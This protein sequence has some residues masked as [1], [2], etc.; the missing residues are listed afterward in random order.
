MGSDMQDY[1]EPLQRLVEQFRRLPGIGGKSAVRMAFA[2]L[3]FSE[4]EAREFSEAIIDAKERITS[5]RRCGNYS[6]GEI[7]PICADPERD[8]GLV[9]VLENARDILA[10]ER[11]REYRGLY[12]VLGGSLSPV[13]GITPDALN[14]KALV[15]RVAEGEIREIIVA[16][17]PDVEGEAT[18]MYLAR[19]LAPY[20]IK[21]TRLA[22]GIPVGG[23]LEY[24]DEVT[25]N[26]ALLGR[27][28]L[29]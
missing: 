28:D 6:V 20:E 16:T 22:Y 9:C 14:I 1:A 17:D 25:L 13:N 23:N 26:R 7:C 15:D 4:E 12:H 29:S 3:S 5:C 18:A 10:F 19:I 8:R 2:V 24:T 11:V 27:R 21:I